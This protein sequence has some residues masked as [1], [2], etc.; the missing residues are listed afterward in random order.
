[1]RKRFTLIW[2]TNWLYSLFYQLRCFQNRNL[3]YTFKTLFTQKQGLAPSPDT[4][5]PT[6]YMKMD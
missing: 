2:A 5:A 4:P 6:F 1:M 3:G